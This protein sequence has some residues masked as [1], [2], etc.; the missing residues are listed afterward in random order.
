MGDGIGLGSVFFS[1]NLSSA[2]Q[3][4]VYGCLTTLDDNLSLNL[5]QFHH[6]IIT[7]LIEYS[8]F[9]KSKMFSY[10][11]DLGAVSIFEEQLGVKLSHSHLKIKKR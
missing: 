9:D 2:A 4:V 5:N 1:L 8:I 6:P 10:L 3:F 7:Q 11:R